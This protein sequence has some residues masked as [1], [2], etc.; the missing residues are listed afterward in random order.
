M[1]TNTNTLDYNGDPIN[2]REQE[3]LDNLKGRKMIWAEMT[4]EERRVA[5][6]TWSETFAIIGHP[7]PLINEKIEDSVPFSIDTV[8]LNE[9]EE[10]H[11]LI[12]PE[13]S[14]IAS[15]RP[16]PVE[17]IQKWQFATIEFILPS[18]ATIQF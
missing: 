5:V 14:G 1:T 7:N 2:E 11:L 12:A 17:V 4:N 13:L 8:K 3:V 18:S 10:L 16:V 6:K 9:D 15:T